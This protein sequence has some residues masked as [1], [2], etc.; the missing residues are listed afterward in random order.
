MTPASI[1][2][3]PPISFFLLPLSG[4]PYSLS[5]TGILVYLVYRFPPHYSASSNKEGFGFVL[6]T[7]FFPDLKSVRFRVGFRKYLLLSNIPAIPTARPPAHTTPILPSSLT[8]RPVGRVRSHSP[9]LP[10]HT[11]VG[12]SPP[13]AEVEGAA[14]TCWAAHGLLY[15]KSK[16][17]RIQCMECLLHNVF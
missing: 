8:C 5:L 9:A 11:P 12:S 13:V 2:S 10:A 7:A 15:T 4:S 14:H 16:I 17:F 6:L 1:I 3:S